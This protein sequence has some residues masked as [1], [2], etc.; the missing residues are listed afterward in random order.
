MKLIAHSGSTKTEWCLVNN[1]HIVEHVFTDGIN[2]HIQTRR[3]ISR[4]VRLQLPGNYFTRKIEEVIFYGSGCMSEE[5]QNI[6]KA[7]LV[8]Q[9]RTHT[10]IY[11]DLLAAGRALFG[12]REGIAC[13]LGTG[14]NSCVYDGEDIIDQVKSLGYIL[15]DEGS[16]AALG[17]M[18]ISDCLKNLAP[19]EIMET[20]YEIYQITD[21]DILER[22]YE[23]PFPM[24]SL[25]LFSFFL[26][27]LQEHEYVHNLIAENFRN[28]F[29]RCIMQY[30]YKNLPIS[31]IG[32]IAIRYQEILREVAKEFKIDITEI[33]QSPMQGLVEYDASLS[34]EK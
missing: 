24:R 34:R 11:N 26:A 10:Y 19:Q 4:C 12:K 6:V 3:E 21:D 16:G 9:F 5:K 31:F 33:A 23:K 13:M 17:K 22:I 2:P 32:S 1:G 27:E 25:S 30:D 18:F 29:R 15:G 14:S 7:S 20:F 8:S 28:F